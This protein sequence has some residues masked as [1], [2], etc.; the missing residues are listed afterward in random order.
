MKFEEI[1]VH[2]PLESYVETSVPLP[3]PCISDD[4]STHSY[5]GSYLSFESNSKHDEHA[6]DEPQQMPKWAQSTI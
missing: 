5:H 6:N 4:E 3:P 1:L 2:V